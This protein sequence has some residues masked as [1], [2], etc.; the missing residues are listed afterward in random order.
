MVLTVEHTKTAWLDPE[1]ACGMPS[2]H[3]PLSKEEQ[4]SFGSLSALSSPLLEKLRDAIHHLDRENLQSIPGQLQILTGMVMGD[5]V[6]SSLSIDPEG[7]RRTARVVRRCAR[8]ATLQVE[9][10]DVSEGTFEVGRLLP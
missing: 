3:S 10:Y 2:A 1:V 4:R 5:S 9:G 8:E 7:S 6:D